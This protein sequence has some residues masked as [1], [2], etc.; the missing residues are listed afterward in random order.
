MTFAKPFT[1]VNQMHLIYPINQSN[2]SVVEVKCG[3]NTSMVCLFQTVLF[4]YNA[5]PNYQ[6]SFYLEFI[7]G[8]TGGKNKGG[9]KEVCTTYSHF[10]RLVKRFPCQT[11]PDSYANKFISRHYKR[12][13]TFNKVYKMLKEPYS[14]ICACAQR[15]P[16]F[17]ILTF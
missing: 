6:S 4:L 17:M 10:A 8:R 13:K 15:S 2:A 11:P 12:T 9:E 3:R 5:L 16:L 7:H 1:L 14:P